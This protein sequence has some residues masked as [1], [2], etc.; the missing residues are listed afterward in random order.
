MSTKKFILTLQSTKKFTIML[1]IV[2]FIC[3]TDW[4]KQQKVLNSWITN[5]NFYLKSFII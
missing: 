2:T 1:K 4:V 3:L 5:T